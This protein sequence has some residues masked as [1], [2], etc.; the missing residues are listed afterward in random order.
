MK[1][2]YIPIVFI[3]FAAFCSCKKDFLDAKPSTEIVAPSSLSELQGLLENTPVLNTS[4]PALPIMA[5]D[6][7]IFIDYANWLSTTTKTERNSYVWAKDL[8]NGENSRPDWNLGYKAIFYCNS[9]LETLPKIEVKKDNQ[10]QYNLINGWALFLRSYVMYDLAQS[11]TKTYNANSASTDLGL[12]IR[13]TAGVDQ[14]A[15]RASLQQTYDQILLDLSEAE[16][17]LSATAPVNSNR[18]SKAAVYALYARIYLSMREYTLA[19][20]YA[21]LELTINSK[22]IDYNTLSKT[23]AAPFT[24]NNDE[25]VFN[26]HAVASSYS[27]I[28]TSSSNTRITVNP[29]LLNLYHPKDLRL[30]IYFGT[31]ATSGKLWFKRRNTGDLRTFSGLATD[32]IYLIKAECLARR[33]QITEAMDWLN[34]LLKKRFAPADYLPISASTQPDAL[35]KVL[36]E[37]RKELLFSPL[38]WSDLKRLNLEGANINLTRILNG[39]TYTLAPNDPRYVF[40]IPD[41]EILATGIK[42]NDR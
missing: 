24:T 14:V 23:A 28:L 40:P 35:N 38:R 19:E 3:F 9:I 5:S 22:L 1:R 2:N 4:S 41:D 26:F 18:P 42:Q 12:P 29:E 30:N 34:L 20:K 13:L 37:R 36:L 17:L 11:F 16:K 39:V 8:F 27:I 6:D 21:D 25:T 15:D 7:Y 32:E 33:N 10:S 31:N